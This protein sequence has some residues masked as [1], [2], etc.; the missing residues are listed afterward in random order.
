HQFVFCHHLA[1]LHIAHPPPHHT[2][3]IRRTQDLM[4]KA[5]NKDAV[6]ELSVEI[7]ANVSGAVEGMGQVRKEADKTAEA[8][9]RAGNAAASA[10]AK[11][12]SSMS[13]VASSVK[14]ATSSVNDMRSAMSRVTGIAGAIAGAVASVVGVVSKINELTRD[15]A[16]LAMEYTNS[17]SGGASNAAANLEAVHKRLLELNSELAFKQEHP[18]LGLLSRREKQIREEIAQLESTARGLS[19]QSRALALRQAEERAAAEAEAAKKAAEERAKAEQE[20]QNRSFD[21]LEKRVEAMTIARLEGID[22]I[23]AEEKRALKELED[24]WH[25]A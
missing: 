13:S 4:A 22:R 20:A 1:I 12:T 23:N 10:G 9:G 3:R 6:A 16:L 5:R 19:E 11:T 15:G 17:L 7:G 8:M 2:Q 25:R 14:D 21:A 18:I 24:E